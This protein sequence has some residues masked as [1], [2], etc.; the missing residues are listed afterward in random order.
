MSTSLVY[1][2]PALMFGQMLKAKIAA[3]DTSKRAKIELIGSRL[4]TVFGV[5]LVAIGMKA[6]F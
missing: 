5:F 2:L 6:A 1:V 3:G 4:I